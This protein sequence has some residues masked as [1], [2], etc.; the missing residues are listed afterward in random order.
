MLALCSG[1]RAAVTKELVA[2]LGA[3]QELGQRLQAEMELDLGQ[4]LPMSKRPYGDA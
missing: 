4:V 2:G 3:G 1:W